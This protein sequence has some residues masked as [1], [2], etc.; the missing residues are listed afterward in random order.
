MQC[1]WAHGRI[2][3]GSI[4]SSM[5][6]LQDISSTVESLGSSAWKYALLV[7]GVP[8]DS[9]PVLCFES[10]FEVRGDCLCFMGTAVYVLK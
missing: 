3:R 4:I 10:L 8:A 9:I 6:M 5:Q 1:I 7:S 2:S